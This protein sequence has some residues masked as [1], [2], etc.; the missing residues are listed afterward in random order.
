MIISQQFLN[1]YAKSNNITYYAEKSI[2]NENAFC[3][4]ESSDGSYD[5]FLSHSYLDKIQVLALVRLFN[6]H[7]F[8][9]Y[10][11]WIED[12]QLDR[13]HV[14]DKTANLLRERMKQSKSLSYLTTKNIENSKWCPW[15]LGYF[16]GLKNSKCCILPIMEYGSKFNGQEY[17]GLYPY[18][19]YASH[20]GIDSGCDFYICNQK[21]T[22]FM[23]LREW[24]KG[25][26]KF[27]QGILV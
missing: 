15:E 13:D 25:S 2:I 12:N 1:S 18:L 3:F 8:S 23:R 21:R 16:D 22:E 20:A 10:V 6:K 17:L 19:E 24:I 27:S 9:V 11:D 5:V 26:T 4:E 7:H 14:N